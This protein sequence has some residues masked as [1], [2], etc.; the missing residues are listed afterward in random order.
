MPVKIVNALTGIGTNHIVGT[1]DEFDYFRVIVED[2]K[3]G[4][5]LFYSN[6]GEYLYHVLAERFRGKI[7][8]LESSIKFNMKKIDQE[9]NNITRLTNKKALSKIMDLVSNE[10]TVTFTVL[11]D[12][13]PSDTSWSVVKKPSI[14]RTIE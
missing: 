3:N 8:Y 13:V 1:K 2:G 7:E 14:K 10:P 5:K 9:W 12:S 4:K 6:K 11:S